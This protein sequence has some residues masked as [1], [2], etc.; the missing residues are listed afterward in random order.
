[1]L[2]E[3]ASQTTDLIE[4]ARANRELLEARLLQHGGI[5][6]RGFRPLSVDEFEQ[7]IKIVADD[8]LDYSYRSTPRTRISGKVFTSTEYPAHQSIPLHNENAY[9]RDWPM[10][11]WFLS[12]R[13]AAT[14][15]ETPIADSRR[16]YRRIPANIRER[17]ARHGVMYVRNYGSGLDLSWQEVFQTTDK[18]EVENYCRAAVM[19]LQ[20]LA[21]YRL[22]T[23]QGCHGV[24][25]DPITREINWCYEA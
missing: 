11:I 25:A 20:W 18:T 10:K 14:G 8:L 7:L 19:D 1:M 22:R 21:D 17:F 15:G 6:F 23:R 3:S 9:A 13:S 5:L 4:W 12:L 2:V 16:V 24:A